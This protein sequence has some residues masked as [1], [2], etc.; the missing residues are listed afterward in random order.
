[1]WCAETYQLYV[2]TSGKA[3]L[4]STT[5]YGALRGLETFA[6][7]VEWQPASRQGVALRGE[8]ALQPA[9]AAGY[10]VA[11]LPIQI[12]DKPRYAWRGLMLDT[13]RHF[14]PVSTLLK[15]IDIMSYNKFNTLQ[16]VLCLPALLTLRLASGLG[17][18]SSTF[19]L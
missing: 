10:V 15:Q 16:Y 18:N 4:N 3:L 7:L 19:V 17:P 2:P 8:T 11:G 1:M 13:A 5:V 14:L 6:Q 9:A 12:S